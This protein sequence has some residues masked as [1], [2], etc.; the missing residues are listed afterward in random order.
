MQSI[1]ADT[2]CDCRIIA[3]SDEKNIFSNYTKTELRR[4]GLENI[5]IRYCPGET[6]NAH[7]G[8]ADVLAMEKLFT[9][10]PLETVLSLSTLTIRSVKSMV[11]IWHDKVRHKE[12]VD[13]L[14]GGLKSDGTSSLA[15]RIYAAGLTYSQIKNK[16]KVSASY[17]AFSD[18]LKSADVR[19]HPGMKN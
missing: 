5:Y 10:T 12:S 1:F 11:S 8:F 7:R 16:Y 18:W 4:L 2:L 6:Y 15:A 3:K 9:T 13:R 14:L 19:V 17:E